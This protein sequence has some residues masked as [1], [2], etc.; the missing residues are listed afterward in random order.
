MDK[1]EILIKTGLKYC[2]VTGPMDFYQLSMSLKEIK[3]KLEAEKEEMKEFGGE[4]DNI[5]ECMEGFEKLV[6][7]FVKEKAKVKVPYIRYFTFPDP[8]TY[9]FAIGCV[10]GLGGNKSLTFADTEKVLEL[11]APD[12]EIIN[13]EDIFN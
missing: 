8:A 12:A 1:K 5:A 3:K 6:A 7:K 13:S 11:T 9:G 10:V 4:A 2:A